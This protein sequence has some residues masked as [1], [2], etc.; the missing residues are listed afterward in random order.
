VVDALDLFWVVLN[1]EEAEEIWER[2]GFYL[3]CGFILRL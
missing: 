3:L 2:S 1:W